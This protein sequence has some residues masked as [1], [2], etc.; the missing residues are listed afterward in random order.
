MVMKSK[1]YDL[2]IFIVATAVL[3]IAAAY[4]EYFV[5]SGF[6]AEKFIAAVVERRDS[7]YGITKAG[8]STLWMVGNNGKI[9]CSTDLGKT[10]TAQES[11]I[12]KH[13]Q[14]V[15]AWDERRAVACGNDGIVLV[16]Q[17]G[18]KTWTT[19]EVPKSEIANKLIKVKTIAN[20]RAWAV[21]AMG[22]VISTTDWGATW[23]RRMEEEDTAWNDI[24]FTDEKTAVLVGEFGKIRRTE[25]GGNTWQT[26]TSP[27][28]SS[29]LALAARDAENWVAVGLDGLMIISSD[30]GNA[31][32]LVDE[33]ISKEHLLALAWKGDGWVAV[34]NLGVVVFG[35][36]AADKWETRQLSRTDLMWHTDMTV[37]ASGIFIVGGTQGIY[38]GGEWSYIIF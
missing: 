31:W 38:K 6:S 15:A 12:T 5:P 28:E 26:V 36:P 3:L 33:K 35:S 34:G 7:M 30:G 9:V 22:M 11:G 37:S 29:I 24:V 27:V 4:S 13:L 2:L 16:T 17:D 20:G 8:D 25:D 18:G 32:R 1:F 10:W 14:G 21:G 19:P 23:T